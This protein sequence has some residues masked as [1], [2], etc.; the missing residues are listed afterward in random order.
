MAALPR[1]L[2]GRGAIE[3]RRLLPES[4]IDRMETPATTLAAEAG[5]RFGYGLGLDSYAD[6]GLVW[7]GHGGDGDGYL[8]H[9]AYQREL[10]LG[11][12]VTF[13][14]FNRRA[15]G[16]MQGVIRAHL[17]EGQARPPGAVPADL[18]AAELGALA[19]GYEP[20]TL[21]FAHAGTGAAREIRRDGAGLRVSGGDGDSVRL[22]PVT[23]CLF[24]RPEEPVAT[25]AFVSYEGALY[26][27]GEDGS[28][29][30][31]GQ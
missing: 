20:A 30:R 17:S 4:A 9:F 29:R 7:H 15:L 31:V 19:G 3:G 26:W 1:L 10:G 2:L 8:S 5:R 12:F 13:N 18:G 6:Q 16:E 21:R 23:R 24:R 27:Q 14:A 28:Y 22:I 11:Y 25:S